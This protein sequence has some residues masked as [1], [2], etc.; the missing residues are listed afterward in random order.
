MASVLAGF[1]PVKHLNGSSFNNQVNR[2]TCPAAESGAI[3]VGDLVIL[4]ATASTTKYPS[5]SRATGT[6]AVVPIGVVVGFEPDYSNLN[7]SGNIRLA[8]TLRTALVA[9]ATDIVF[10][11]PQDA[12]GGVIGLA[13]IG[14]NVALVAG[15]AA[16]TGAGASTMLLDSSDVAVT[17]TYPLRIVGFTDAPD[18]DE[19]STARP[20]E[21]LV[22]INTHRLGSGPGVA[23]I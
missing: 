7:T 22:T 9:D 6:T 11:A 4:S 23:G 21:V 1:R 8:S 19:T 2:Y 20:A 16:T 15:T 10:A 12:V 5:I 18:N 17:S 3:N 13:S 14:L